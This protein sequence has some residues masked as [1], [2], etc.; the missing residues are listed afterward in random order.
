MRINEEYTR[1]LNE[2]LTEQ[3]SPIGDALDSTAGVDKTL[4]D[5]DITWEAEGGEDTDPATDLDILH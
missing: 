2:L 4:L 1:V 5:V 3:F